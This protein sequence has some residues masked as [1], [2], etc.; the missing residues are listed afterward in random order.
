M[1]WAYSFNDEALKLLRKV[2]PE[3]RRRIIA[4]LDSN[5]AGCEDPRMFGKRLK[6]DFSELWRFRTGHYRII[7][8]LRDQEL[9]IAV[10]RVGHRRDVYD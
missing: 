8:Q 6:G 5:I 9:V 10:V 7:A 4:Y 3:G 1:S 2:G